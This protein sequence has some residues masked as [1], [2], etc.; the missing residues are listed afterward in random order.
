MYFPTLA[1]YQ[2][3]MRLGQQST[4]TGTTSSP[5]APRHLF[6]VPSTYG[7]EDLGMS[8]SEQRMAR[9]RALFAMSEAFGN[10]ARTGD[11]AGGLASAGSAFMDTMSGQLEARRQMQRQREQDSRAEQ[12]SEDSHL[13]SLLGRQSEQQQVDLRQKAVTDKE[14]ADQRRKTTATSMVH[15]IETTAGADSP[16]A[17]QARAL[18]ELGEDVDMQRL[19][20][21]HDSATERKRLPEDA[22]LKTQLLIEQSQAQAKEG[23]GPIA[24]GRRAQQG[25][26]FEAQRIGIDRQRLA[27]AAAAGSVGK[28]PTANQ[29]N[30]DIK[31]E[32]DVLFKKRLDEM[33]ANA[34]KLVLA[35]DGKSY[36][37]KAGPTMAEITA[38]RREADAAAQAIVFRRYGLAPGLAHPGAAGPNLRYIP[39]SDSLVPK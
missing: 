35:K 36:E 26:G 5:T 17:R 29:I 39:D 30:D 11:F 21:I 19:V 10:S 25:L 23:F 12:A 7:G 24:E 15:E 2:M 34:G 31:A 37:R 22:R 8:E 4:G 3:R 16:E 14:E 13:S 20:A 27:Q 32:S 6:G 9:A 38:A 1:L 18:L 28:P 33:A